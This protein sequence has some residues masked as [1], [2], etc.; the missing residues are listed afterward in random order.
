MSSGW[1]DKKKTLP[2]RNFQYIR[3]HSG[4]GFRLAIARPA[5]FIRSGIYYRGWPS[6]STRYHCP[7]YVRL[8]LG[9][10]IWHL[11]MNIINSDRDSASL[12]EIDQVFLRCVDWS[13]SD[14]ALGTLCAHSLSNFF[15]ES[16]GH[17]VSG[18]RL[19]Q[20]NWLYEVNDQVKQVLLVVI[21]WVL[22]MSQLRLR[23]EVVW[24]ASREHPP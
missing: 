3:R 23:F 16:S 21:F 1:D 22:F 8:G 11:P 24:V 19:N 12:E 20:W 7:T 5:T 17:S 10:C 15:L 13:S 6:V 2:H 18:C 9:P 14:P 4:S